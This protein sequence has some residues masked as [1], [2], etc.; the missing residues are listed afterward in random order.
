MTKQK[1][2]RASQYQAQT[3]AGATT[4]APSIDKARCETAILTTAT[5]AKATLKPNSLYPARSMSTRGAVEKK[6][7]NAPISVPK[8]KM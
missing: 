6:P 8:A 7:K 1:Q 4:H 5:I 2:K 3:S